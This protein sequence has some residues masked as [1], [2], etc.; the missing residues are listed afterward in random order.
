[1][2]DFIQVK[3][4]HSLTNISIYTSVVL[5]VFV[6]CKKRLPNTYYIPNIFYQNVYRINCFQPIDFEFLN[7]LSLIIIR[8]EA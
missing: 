3:V 6:V 8:L 1:M 5:V 4:L 2:I 7:Y